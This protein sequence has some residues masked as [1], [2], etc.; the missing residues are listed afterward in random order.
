MKTIINGIL[1]FLLFVPV[2]ILAQ[3]SIKGT[4]T[5]QS[6]SLPLPGVNILVKG[7]TNGT[8]SDF[9]GEYQLQ[10]NQGD[11]ITFTFIGYQSQEITYTGQSVIDVVLVEDAA[12]LDEVVVIGYGS[13]KKEDLTGSV[14]VVSSKEFNKGAIVSADQLL[15]GKAPGVR[16]TTAGG[17]PDAEPNIRIRSGASLSA[18][19]S[20]LIVIDGIAIDNTNPAGVKNPL[21][22][23]NPNDIESF[24]V[25]K[26]AS[27]TAIYGSRASN[28]VIIITTK[29]GTSGEPQFNFSTSMSSNSVSKKIDVL[30]GSEFVQFINEYEA[31]GIFE[32][33][34]SDRL[35]V[36]INSVDTREQVIQTFTDSNGMQRGIYNTDWQ[37]AIYRT[38]ISTN[39]DFS[40]RANLFEK[41]PFRA[42]VGYN[43]TEGVV[44]TSDYERITA[45]LKL[46]PKFFQDHLKVDLNLKGISADKN[47]IDEGGALF[48]AVVMDPTKPIYD[49]NSPFGGYFTTTSSTSNPTGMLIGQSNPLALLMQRT[50][51]EETQKILGNVEFDYKMHFLPEL[52]AV[53]NLGVEASRST[54]EENYSENAISTYRLSNASN[55]YIFN[56]GV[57]FKEN[58]H[59][60]NT[61]LEGYLV[62][63]KSYDDSFINSFEVQ[64]GYGYQN[65]KNDGNKEQYLYNTETGL[66]E[67][68]VNES[69]PNFRYYN[70]LNLQSFF[71]RSNINI[72]D[73][74]L[75]TLSVRADASSLFVTDDVWGNDVWGI[76]PAAA[77][78]WKLKEESFLR[79][80][81]FVQE[82][83]LRLGYG[84]TGQQD[85]TGLAGG[86]FPSTPLFTVGNSTT[87][88]L[89]G[90]S[91]YSARAY[92]ENLTWEKTT[93]YNAGLDFSFFNSGALSGSFDV[94]KRKTKDLLVLAP[95]AP[96]QGF[97]NLFPQNIGET[98]N[99]GFELN[100]GITPV[101]NDDFS[102]DLNGN[103]AYSK[104]EVTNLNGVSSISADESTIPTGTGVKLARHAVGE[105]VY[106]A[107]VF[108]Q[109]YDEN[110]RPILGAFV[111]LNG[112]GQITN[113]DR[114]YKALRPNWTFGLGFSTQYK[115]WDLS[116]S[117]RGQLDGQMYN[118]RNL[119]IGYIEAAIPSNTESLNNV[120]DFYNGVSDT[121]F[122]NRN[123]NVPFSDYYLENASFLRCENIT[124]GLTVGEAIKDVSFKVYASVNNPFVITDYSGQDPENFNAI[125]NNF[126]PRPRVYT[127]GLNID[128]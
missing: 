123:G 59:I 112:D 17:Q 101:E 53:L 28:G 127:L 114:Y 12:S 76:F 62:Y 68:Q 33:G 40:A 14:D 84:K 26:D 18:N 35:G 119:A 125:D 52:R 64:G 51:P 70:V 8:A 38:A 110:H 3:T 56:P 87:Q 50:R 128:F 7:T 57:N 85:I 66:R 15:N 27:A 99:E 55:S 16:I 60:T 45:S 93:T 79:D 67:L 58:Q 96:G 30:D 54:I 39:Y 102:L 9:D 71:G 80:A 104:T 92:N 13:V 122:V 25:L 42:S 31:K 90:V 49:T 106:S 83:K 74:F 4:V 29:K 20:P 44:K 63:N 75:V 61:T 109:V 117:F 121:N 24:S 73:K 46:T 95:V 78:A 81:D 5:E 23:V 100:L 47:A 48:G 1:F 11:V 107:W 82:L 65:F 94:F 6:T 88:Y 124:L 108:K 126:Y 22:L 21:T 116:A 72:L 89:P 69:N 120:V 41:I 10:V 86:Y 32:A 34:T 43:N 98:E 19:S 2:T 115:N 111:D 113:D 97:T 77:L 105:E 36:P 103:I 91:L 37:D 118:T